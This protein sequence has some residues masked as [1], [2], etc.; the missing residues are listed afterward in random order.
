MSGTA[1]D[2]LPVTLDE[3]IGECRR[4]IQQRHQVYPRWVQDK[5]LTA[6]RAARQIEIM[7]AIMALLISMNEPPPTLRK[8]A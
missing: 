2:L 1:T 3:M 8:A 5:R 4:E 7:Q 6:R